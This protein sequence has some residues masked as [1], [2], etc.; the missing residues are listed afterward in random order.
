[1]AIGGDGVISVASH[2][3]GK[4][5]K[6]MVRSYKEGNI[7]KACEIHL[8]LSPL[9]KA[10]FMTTNP[11]MVKSAV[12]LKGIDVGGLRPPLVDATRDQI[13]K[14]EKVMRDAGVL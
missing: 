7:E 12:K 9:F 14:L 1:L 2:V 3:A 5:I 8:T 10:L 11:I 13:E 4:E 6:E